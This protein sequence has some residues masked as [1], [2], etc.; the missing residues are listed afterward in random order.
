MLSKRKKEGECGVGCLLGV[1]VMTDEWEVSTLE[2]EER[3]AVC[4]GKSC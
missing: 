3:I 4:G 1:G 2:R